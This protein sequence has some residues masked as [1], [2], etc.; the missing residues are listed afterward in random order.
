MKKLQTE[1]ESRSW[2]KV[3]ETCRVDVE[4]VYRVEGRR[5]VSRRELRR[6]WDCSDE[7]IKRYVLKGMPKSALSMP[8][9]TV[10]DLAVV[11]AWRLANIDPRLG[12]KVTQLRKELEANVPTLPRG[13]HSPADGELEEGI[14]SG[15]KPLTQYAI[16]EAIAESERA[17]ENALI[18][19]LKRQQMDGSLIDSETLDIALAEQAVI[20]TTHY[21]NDKKLLPIQLENKSRA[22]IRQFLDQY[23]A[24]RMT[25]LRSLIERVFT[26][27]ETLY[28][29]VQAVLEAFLKGQ[30]PKGVIEAIS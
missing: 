20:Y 22:E 29:V 15:K 23:Y 11:D 1:T 27:D 26:C 18:A 14:P 3:A 9:F 5:I 10:F 2:E 17:V 13:E 4:L 19:K 7:T 30:D 8:S 16:D 25:D 28:D 6:L 24:N 12:P 21:V